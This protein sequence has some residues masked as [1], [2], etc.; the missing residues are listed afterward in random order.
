MQTKRRHSTTALPL[1]LAALLASAPAP[2]HAKSPANGVATSA[3]TSVDPIS[4][5]DIAGRQRMLSQRMAKA[6]LLLA[7]GV[8]V[9][10]SRALLAA[11]IERFEAQLAVLKAVERSAEATAA[12]G[13]LERQWLATKAVL[14]QPPSRAGADALYDASEA[15][16]SAAHQVTLAL[17]R[18]PVSPAQRLVNL[19]GRQRMLTQR[20]AK[21]HL[22]RAWDAYAEAADMELHAS[23]AHFTAVLLRIER[24]HDSAAIGDAVRRVREQWV[25]YEQA[26]L[27]S[28]D[29][30]RI[31]AGAAQMAA[32]SERVLE[33]TEQLV[34]AVIGEVRQPRR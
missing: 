28:R 33:A 26:L 6:Y 11:S 21:F 16:Q 17:E 5:I 34:A 29:P 14:V 10:E 31:R 1:A 27:A 12:L 18:G 13:G 19:A 32:A 22:Y 30:V 24:S 9:D 8:A 4:A 3:P 23:R 2:A 20:M 25:P 7:M 15:L